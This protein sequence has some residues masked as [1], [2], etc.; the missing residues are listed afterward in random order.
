MPPSF[1]APASCPEHRARWRVARIA[2][3]QAGHRI[4]P[5]GPQGRIGHFWWMPVLKAGLK[6][7]GL[8][9]R[10]L[11]NARRLQRVE[12]DLEFH[13]LPP[14]F[15]GYRIL[16]VSDMHLDAIPGHE[17]NI[18][19]ALKGLEADLAV[20]TG[21][22]RAHHA[23]ATSHLKEP[24]AHV[25]A[26]CTVKDGILATLGNHDDHAIPEVLADLGIRVLINETVALARG[27]ETL[28][29]TGLDDVFSFHTPVAD[30]ALAEGRQDGGFSVALIHSPEMAEAAA[31]HGYALYLCGHTH[32]GQIALPGGRAILTLGL[33]RAHVA[34]LWRV[35]EMLGYT[36]TGAGTSGVPVRFFSPGEVTLFTLRRG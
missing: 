18:V 4:S 13:D 5:K 36:S 9:N 17:R 24:L 1:A 11:A 27:G 16:Q 26:A 28:R 29:F 32:G 8:Y 10:G 14:T 31:R 34:G 23:G 6:T 30:A 25:A 19:A 22:Y 7:V 2:I 21:D 35:G 15:D 12:I 20:W 33:P 3:E